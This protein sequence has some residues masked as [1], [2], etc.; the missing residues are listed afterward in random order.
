MVYGNWI[1]FGTVFVA[2][3]ALVLRQCWLLRADQRIQFK[4]K[5]C[6]LLSVMVVF[7]GCSHRPK[8]NNRPKLESGWHLKIPVHGNWCGPN[9][10]KNIEDDPEPLD[11]LDEA[12]KEHDLCYAR[13]GYTNEHCD[14]FLM[15]TLRHTEW[16]SVKQ[17]IIAETI[18]LYFSTSPSFRPF[19]DWDFK[20]EPSSF[21]PGLTFEPFGFKFPHYL[22]GLIENF[23]S[24]L[25]KRKDVKP[26]P[27]KKAGEEG[28]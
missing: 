25:K 21:G 3:L 14:T 17:C 4:K 27:L 6:L 18:Q 22:K 19:A 24:D 26:K 7:C 12:C 5:A 9:H 8:T 20:V 16:D 13:R 23:D 28:R 11:E 10:P 1:A 2:L 15:H